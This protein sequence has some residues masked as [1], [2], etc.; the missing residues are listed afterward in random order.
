M[1]AVT[2]APVAALTAAIIARVVFDMLKAFEGME[3]GQ[4]YIVSRGDLRV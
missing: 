1:A 3:G 2:P 4:V